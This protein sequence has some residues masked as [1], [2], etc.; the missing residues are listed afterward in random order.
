MSKEMKPF[1]P[2]AGLPADLASVFDVESLAGDLTE[3]AGGAGFQVVSIRGS[4]WRIKSQGE[5]HVVTNDDDDPIP[6]IEVV[7]LKANKGVSK[8]FYEKKYTEG[9]DGSPT[10]FSVDG[11]APDNSSEKKQAKNCAAC[12]MNKW[13]SRMTEAGKKA[14]ACADTRRVA[15][16]LH[17]PCEGVDPSEPMLLRVPAASLADLH[18]YGTQMQNKGYPYNALVTRLGFDHNASY[19]KLT[20]KPARPINEDEAAEVV[21]MFNSETTGHIL[22]VSET[23]VVEEETSS[24]D[25]VDNTVSTDFDFETETVQDEKPKQVSKKKA[26]KKQSRKAPDKAASKG[27][28][29][30]DTVGEPEAPGENEG[31]AGGLDADLDSI[32]NDLENLT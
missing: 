16:W 25:A 19:P 23:T 10:C 22:S 1:N 17:T 30:P 14:K 32:L 11:V 2:T 3:G 15:I 26:S 18:S 13:G 27:E 21:R 6:S 8:I 20:F 9:D 29:A 12:K 7:M 4:K 5:E 24:E 28:S 31:T